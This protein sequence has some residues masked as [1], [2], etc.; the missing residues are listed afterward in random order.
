[1]LT[2]IRIDMAEKIEQ[3]L[4]EM[5]EK[6]IGGAVIRVDGIIEHSTVA[7]NDISAGLIASTANISDMLMQKMGD[8]QKEMETSFGSLILVM[9]P[10]KNYIFCGMI[11]NREE[12]KVVLEYAKKAES[13]L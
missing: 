5:K 1:M 10:I 13:C 2:K 6:D 4:N 8:K 12:K 11:R 7:L 3:I 9:V